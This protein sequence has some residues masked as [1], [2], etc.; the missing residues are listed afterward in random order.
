MKV[1]PNSIASLLF[2]C[3]S[4]VCSAQKNDVSQANITKIKL[5]LE[6]SQNDKRLVLLDSLCSLTQNSIPFEYEKTVNETIALAQELGETTVCIKHK[7]NLIFYLTN[8]VNRP[9]EGLETFL[10]VSEKDIT[11]CDPEILSALYANGGDSYL[12]SGKIEQSIPEYQRSKEFALKAND[13]LFFGK[14]LNY[15]ASAYSDLGAYAKASNIF[16]KA[17]SI[18]TKLGNTKGIMSAKI[19]LANLYSKIGFIDEAESE[20]KEILDIIADSKQ[21]KDQS[22]IPVLYN[23][24]IDY[25]KQ[26]K[27][28]QRLD[29]LNRAYTI[30][31][32]TKNIQ[33][34]PIITYSLLGAYAENDNVEK[35]NYFYKI[36]ENR[37]AN[38][39]PIP[40]EDEYHNAMSRYYFFRKQYD[41][42]LDESFNVLKSYETAQN[43]E[44]IYVTKNII[45]EI[46][47]Q[48]QDARNALYYYKTSRL[49]SDSLTNIQKANALSY[50]QT[51]YETQI[52]DFTISTQKNDI[53]LL[54]EK[55]TKKQQALLF[56]GM[57]FS[58]LFLFTWLIRSRNDNKK[59]RET[60]E[61]FTQ[62]LL[63]TQEEER[64]KIARD[65]HDSIGQ[66]L[67]LLSRKAKNTANAEMDILASTSLD[68]LRSI[69]RGLYPSIL[70]RL[71]LTT[72]IKV[73]I[74][75]VDRNT[76][77]FFS[78]DIDNIDQLVSKENALHFYR[79][80]QES[81]NNLVKHSG[82]KAATI[83]IEK[84]SKNIYTAVK[85]NGI[86][87]DFYDHK[88]TQNS[89][90]M[91]TLR[92]RTRMIHSK[93]NIISSPKQGT[94]V[95]LFTPIY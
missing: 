94:S 21:I 3:L 89:L 46:Y 92:E 16:R 59:Q 60:Q 82:A 37:Y 7:S 20:R 87:F 57:G 22:L 19:G 10:T 35:T 4:M 83:T 79:I 84:N 75:E 58:M 53:E 95:E 66:K 54:A 64:I 1:I 45:S 27:Q 72:A 44:G 41:K 90:G 9:E 5:L 39:T 2:F 18:F 65:L 55:N 73:L 88:N 29:A 62:Q 12:F 61:M 32:E 11:N 71:G 91:K 38:L 85:D 30:C 25:N 33:L 49:I 93:L 24:A 6:T 43:V 50:Y 14:V 56:G 80:I 31:Q 74:D 63:K 70:E 42:A 23:M 81:L 76:D 13:S 68:E 26:N 78:Y 15:E 77:I 36:I 47:T 8:R 48:K 28:Q 51:L 69:S 52:K 40:I 67:M 34:L 17:I 86:G